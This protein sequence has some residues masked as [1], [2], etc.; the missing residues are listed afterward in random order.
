MNDILVIKILITW[1]AMFVEGWGLCLAVWSAQEGDIAFPALFSTS[2][3][4]VGLVV[5]MVW[6]AT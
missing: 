2:V 4:A 3:P 6:S 1:M 5:Y